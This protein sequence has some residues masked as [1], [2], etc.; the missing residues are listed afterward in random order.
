MEVYIYFTCV[1]LSSIRIFTFQQ[2][3]TTTTTW[4]IVIKFGTITLPQSNVNVFHVTEI[5]YCTA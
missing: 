3:Q 1:S 4:L 5:L 2:Q